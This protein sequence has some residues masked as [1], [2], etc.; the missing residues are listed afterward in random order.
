MNLLG[1]I[2]FVGAVIFGISVLFSC[3]KSGDFGFDSSE[4]TP[5][6]F[7]VH[8]API[9]SSVI[10]LDTVFSSNLNT[11]LIGLADDVN[12]GTVRATTYTRLDL[13]KNFLNAISSSAI[14]DSAKLNFRVTYLRD[15]LRRNLNLEV[16]KLADPIA[17]TVFITSNA[18]AI[19]NELIVSGSLFIEDLDSIYSAHV[20]ADFANSLFEALRTNDP[21][22]ESQSTFEFF[23]P[24]LAFTTTGVTENIFRLNLDAAS[25]ITFYYR[26]LGNSGEIDL[27]STHALTFGSLPH[28]Y[29]LEVNRSASDLA[30]L[31]QTNVEFIPSSNLRYVQEATGLVTKID[32][33]SLQA[34]SDSNP[35]II[36][37]SAQISLGPIEDFSDGL[38]PPITFF[39]A[40]TDDENTIIR[41]GSTFRTM[42][43]D[44]ASPIGSNAPVQLTYNVDTKTYTASI[45]SFVESYF[46]G[47]YRRNSFFVYPQSINNS[48]NQ[49][50]FDPNNISIKIY[51][52]RL[53]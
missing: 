1:K 40:L 34:F 39:L 12:L 41:D 42:Q 33:S 6:E 7:I 36:I 13:R 8:Q 4:L 5:V 11:G 26:D 35:G 19:S 21:S 20:S 44:G 25:N 18:T 23:F 15:T 28:Y 14:L 2:K 38:T 3:E 29:G 43:R 24:G 45:T 17:D 16:Y 31:R 49:I 37:N 51:Y 9:S 52:S 53:R 50:I 30:G 22:V 10:Q 27:A 48:L 32:V 47:A 46:T